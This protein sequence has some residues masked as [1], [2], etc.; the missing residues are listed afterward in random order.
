MKRALITGITGQDGS[1]LAE[2]LVGKG[3][4]VHGVIRRAS[5]FNTAR[6]DHLY[7]DQHEGE[8]HLVLHY[9]DLTDGT[10]LRKILEKVR[11]VEIYNLA[12][13]SHV[14]VSFEAPEYS[15]DV[16]ATGTLRLLET[17]RDY[18]EREGI[19]VRVYQAGSS[20]MFGAAK[21]P[22]S[23]ATPFYPRSP[24]AVAKVA[25]HWFAVNYREAYDL[26][27]CNGILFNHESP[28]RGETFVTRKITRAVGRIKHGLQQRLYLGNLDAK[29][30]WGFA[31]DYV[32]AMWLM[33]QQDKPD[34]YV[35]AT[36]EA[37]SVREF[38]HEAFAMVGLDWQAH[39]EIDPRYFRPTEVDF[40]QGDP[41]KV[42][43]QLGWTPR[44]G[45]QALVR[46]MV[47]HDLDL[48]TQERTLADAGFAGRQ[49]GAAHG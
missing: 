23:E 16:V 9:G 17:V 39:V 46:M 15:A 10:G 4:Q 43:R 3:Y 29:R 1:Y 45:F 14:K 34:D 5:S 41:A 12:A 24:Y 20:E 25:A 27:V 47:E 18:A 31:G 8:P 35:V 44:V 22:Q 49:K 26:F 36:G 38:V 21:P 40:L 32:E 7:Q 11:P 30:D 13:Q 37:Y 48:A 28:R 6:I 2:L 19:K 33:L 42:K